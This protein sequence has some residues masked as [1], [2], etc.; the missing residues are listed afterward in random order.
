MKI[1]SYLASLLPTFGRDR[2]LEDCRVTAAE[3]TEQTLPSYA[4]AVQVFKGKF[5]S[6]DL[7]NKAGIFG[8]LSH[9]SGGMIPGI[10]KGLKQ[11]V[12]GLAVAEDLFRRTTGEDIASSA[13]TYQKAQLLQ[14]VE[15][16]T[17]ASKYAR[18]F[19]V[20]VYVLETAE[21]P[22][23]GTIPAESLTP[24]ERKWLEENFIS[25]CNA[26]NVL[27][28]PELKLKKALTEIPDVVI[29]QQNASTL[30]ATMGAGKLDPLGMGII[31]LWCN[32]I[33][34]FRLAVAEWQAGRY[35]AAQEDVKLL[36]LRKLNLERVIAGRPDA[37]LQQEIAYT[38]ARIAKLSYNLTEMERKYGA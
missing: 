3:I 11:G 26:I 20:L 18:K 35:K 13:L 16:C 23:S 14:Y 4:A 19:L 25:F 21:Y 38:E 2:V 8:R 24:A 33:Y 32:P 28:T 17:F 29:T 15:L 1:L 7:N 27:N 31:P 34:H 37:K 10:E 22:E 5:R 9:I 30:P 12:A 6:K 36:Q